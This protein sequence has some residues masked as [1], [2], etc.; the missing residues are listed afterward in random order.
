MACTKTGGKQIPVASMLQPAAPLG[1]ISSAATAAAAAIA[2]L[3]GLHLVRLASGC[4]AR[5]L[6]S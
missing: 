2:T 4:A 6:G 1:C 3:A 5:S